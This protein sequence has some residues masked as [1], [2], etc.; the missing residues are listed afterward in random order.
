MESMT[1]KQLKQRH[2]KE[3]EGYHSSLNLRVHR[4]L[5]WLDRSEQCGKDLDARFIFLWIAFNAVYGSQLSAEGTAPENLVLKNFLARILRL[6][7]GKLIDTMLWHK[8]SGPIRL[9]LQNPYVFP[10][11]WKSQ[12]GTLAPDAWEPLFRKAK[13]QAEQALSKQATLTLLSVLLPRIYMLRN[14][15]VHGGATWQSQ[16]NRDQVRDCTALMAE[17]VP[18][19]ICIMMD[20]PVMEWEPPAYPV[21]L[22]T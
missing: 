7:T 15:L 10:A 17:F 9:L 21:V 1:Y 12:N 18:L 2:R 16:V 20:N 8:Y 4:A 3:R 22:T 13:R 6:D 11:F 14:Q 5:S 19:V